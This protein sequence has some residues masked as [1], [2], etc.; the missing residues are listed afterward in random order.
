MASLDPERRDAAERGDGEAPAGAGV[1][2]NGKTRGDDTA[3][4][5]AGGSGS[6]GA[7][8][9]LLSGGAD[10]DAST[11]PGVRAARE[12]AR[13]KRAFDLAVVALAAVVLLPVWVALVVAI[14]AA[15]RL[16][17]GGSVLYRQPRLGCGGRVFEIVKFRSMAQGAEE[18]TGPVWA[19]RRDARTTAV[20]RVLRRVHLDELPQVVNVLRGEMS[21][22][23]PRP[24]RPELARRIERKVPGFSRR[25]AVRPGIAGLAQARGGNAIGARR[26]LRY[27]LVYIGAMGPW[28][29]L[30]LLVLCAWRALRGP[31][32][33]PGG[34]DRLGRALGG[35]ARG[36]RA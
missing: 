33:R 17:G 5:C 1:N 11:W 31:R 35:E 22:V 34:A 28:L 4:R 10:P 9:V 14:A 23:G 27:D 19:A 30:K 25:L 3:V 18:R 20:G 32:R 8:E 26:K 2:R 7:P 16:G 15:I 13:Y 21:L 24:E 29:D 6:D 12:R 36:Y